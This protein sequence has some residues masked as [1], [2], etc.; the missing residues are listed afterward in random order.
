M[1]P[2]E[3]N[4]L[5]EALLE[6]ALPDFLS[7]VGYVLGQHVVQLLA[8]SRLASSPPTLFKDAARELGCS[9][10]QLYEDRKEG[11]FEFLERPYRIP[12]EEMERLRTPLVTPQNEEYTT[13]RKQDFNGRKASPTASTE[14]S[15]NPSRDG[16][17]TRPKPPTLSKA[18]NIPLP[19]R[20]TDRRFSP[21]LGADRSVQE[22]QD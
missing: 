4:K 17:K 11:K 22:E 18:G 12:A 10:S 3:N 13:R 2:E 9:L 21:T 15:A 7:L 6:L 14:A 19:G 5:Q 1:K 8:P 16:R 20:R